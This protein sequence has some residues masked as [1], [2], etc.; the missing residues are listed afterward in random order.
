MPSHATSVNY[1]K[2][3]KRLF[4]V[5]EGILHEHGI[6]I[7]RVAGDLLAQ[8]GRTLEG[9]IL[10]GQ[11]YLGNGELSITPGSQMSSSSFT[12]STGISFSHS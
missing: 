11:L 3:V 12:S 10:V 6:V 9:G 8:P 5:L 1:N 4:P 7:A 2:I